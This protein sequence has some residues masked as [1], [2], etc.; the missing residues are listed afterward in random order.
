MIPKFYLDSVIDNFLEGE[1]NKMHCDIYEKENKYYIEMDLAG[2]KKNEIKI[3]CNNGNIAI[4][5]EKETKNNEQESTR[6]YL[7]RERVYNKY[8]RSF[9]LGDINEEEIEAEFIDGTLTVI[10]PKLEE[11]DTKKFIDIK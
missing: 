5:A 7:R 11:K 8:S 1:S 4:T 9:Y 10:I 2:F 3:E 6:K